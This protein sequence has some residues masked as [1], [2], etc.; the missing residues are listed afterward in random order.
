MCMQCFISYY[1]TALLNAAE[2]SIH[3]NE[4]SQSSAVNYF[5]LTDRC[6]AYLTAVKENDLFAT[7]SR[8]SYHSAL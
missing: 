3:L 8:I 7:D 1:H 6:S 2:R 5:R 4:P